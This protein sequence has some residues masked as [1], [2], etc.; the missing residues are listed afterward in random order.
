MRFS[1]AP[2]LSV[3][4]LTEEFQLDQLEN[5]WNKLLER[6]GSNTIFLTFEWISTWWKNF[7]AH[8]RL[9]IALVRKE[10]EVIGIFP[11][12][13]TQRE[14]FF[15]ARLYQQQDHRLQGLHHRRRAGSRPRDSERVESAFQSGRVGLSGAQRLSGGLDQLERFPAGA[16]RFIFPK[17]N[18]EGSQCWTLHSRRG[19]MGELLEKSKKII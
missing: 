19:I 15:A 9:F 5:V 18:L 12:M 7:G 16:V 10:N 13:I 11:L 6:S 1:S 17:V 14:F 8:H 4:I 3:Q 2:P